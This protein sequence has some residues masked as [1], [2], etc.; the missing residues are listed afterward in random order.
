M[1]LTLFLLLVFIVVCTI[2][3]KRD[4][5]SF[6]LDDHNKL[7]FKLQSA[8]WFQNHLMSG[9]FLFIMNAMLFFTTCLVLYFYL[10]TD[11]QIPY[12]HLLVMVLAVFA[13][14]FLWIIVSKAWQGTNVNRIKMSIIGSSFYVFLSILF[15]YWRLTLE[16]YPGE[17]LFMRDLGL[18]LGLI[19]SI[20]AF[21]SCLITTGFGYKRK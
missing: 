8:S 2:L 6:M 10:L 7:V 9:I 3:F 13:S 17:D 12:L 1:P 19:V 20:V 21:L 16:A 15:L 5:V 14:F 18:M 4:K 11:L